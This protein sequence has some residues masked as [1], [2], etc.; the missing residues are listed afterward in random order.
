MSALLER[1]IARLEAGGHSAE[2]ERL[3]YGLLQEDG[4]VLYNQF[5]VSRA[6]WERRPGAR[7]ITVSGSEGDPTP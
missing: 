3:V 5:A 7:L 2:Q 1:R 4:T 6:E